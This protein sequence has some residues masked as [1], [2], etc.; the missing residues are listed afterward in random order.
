MKYVMSLFCLNLYIF[1]DVCRTYRQRNNTLGVC[2]TRH[3]VRQRKRGEKY[4]HHQP[5]YWSD[6]FNSFMEKHDERNMKKDS[7]H[8]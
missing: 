1:V 3:N 2:N 6:R 5:H 4:V 8:T 7:S